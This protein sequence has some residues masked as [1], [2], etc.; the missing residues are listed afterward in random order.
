MI[1]S[2]E[3]GVCRFSACAPAVKDE[4]A[5]VRRN[6]AAALARLGDRA[7]LPHIEPLLEDP[8]RSVR[9]KAEWAPLLVLTGP[10]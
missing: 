7:A 10:A 4:D 5:V 6:A 9:A 8:D 1:P 2:C 3:D